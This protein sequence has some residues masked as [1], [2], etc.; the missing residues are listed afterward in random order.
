ML[1]KDALWDGSDPSY[2]PGQSK[3]G[4]YLYWKIPRKYAELGYTIDGRTTVRLDGIIDD[5]NDLDRAFACRKY[6]QA[7]LEHF[8][9]K[10]PAIQ[11]GTWKWLFSRYL[12]DKESPFHEKK[13][14]TQE[15]YRL[16]IGYWEKAI[17]DTLISQANFQAAMRWKKAMANNG[18]SDDHIKRMFTVLRLVMSYGVLI[19]DQEC[20]RFRG[21]LAEMRIASPKTKQNE[22]TPEQISAIVAAAFKAGHHSFVLGCALQWWFAL[23]AADV[24]GQWLE[25]KPGETPSGIINGKLRWTDGLTWD[26]IDSDVTRIQKTISKT[27]ATTGTV[28]VFD[29]TQV[30]EVRDQLL[31]IPLEKRVGPVIVNT[32]TGLP[33]T[34]SGWSTAW[35][36]HRKEAGVPDHVKNMG[37]RAAAITHG[38][39]SG[40][41][42]FQLRDAAGHADLK[43]TG[44]YIRGA[45]EA[46]SKVL[47][48]RRKA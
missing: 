38:E 15:M 9:P 45:D 24:R 32:S 23:R 10:T 35:R 5:G 26:M 17:G 34:R 1:F 12:T 16:F 40:A 37:I 8:S 31:S 33:Y 43:T 30:P 13:A 29:L 4:K 14:N 21:V 2:A 11:V 46:T 36:R 41:S 39:R 48:L 47:N 20:I 28:K 22:G 44:R 3:S 6:T 27:Q 18:R 42:P 7:M 19:E 25:I